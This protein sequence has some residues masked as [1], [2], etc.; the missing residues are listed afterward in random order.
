MFR[1]W[2]GVGRWSE[3]STRGQSAR[4]A[5]GT[6]QGDEET[7][8]PHRMGGTAATKPSRN[9]PI[10]VLWLPSSPSPLFSFAVVM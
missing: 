4:P 6:Q 1:L 10:L 8:S 2:G 9:E 3:L 5:K 7:V